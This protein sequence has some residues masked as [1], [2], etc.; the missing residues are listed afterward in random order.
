MAWSYRK[1]TKELIVHSGFEVYRTEVEAAAV[2]HSAEIG[3]A[4]T[5]NE[6]VIDFLQA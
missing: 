2:I 6:E 3:C 4:I 1:W 5:G